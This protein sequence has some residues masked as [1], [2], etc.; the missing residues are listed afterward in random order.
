MAQIKILAVGDVVG[1]GGTDYLSGGRL[2]RTASSLGADVIVVNGENSSK[3]N[4]ITPD[5]AESLF[6]SGADVIT[7]GNHTLKRYHMYDYLDS[8]PRCLRAANYPSDAPGEGYVITDCGGRRLLVISLLGTTFMDPLDSPFKC[9]DRILESAHGKYDL[10]VVDIHAEATSEKM[11][12]AR[13]LDGRVCAVFGTHTHVQ[14]ADACVLP[15]GTGYITDLGM[16]GPSEG[17]LGVKSENAMHKFLRRTPVYFEHAAGKMSAHGA[18]FT[19]DTDTKKCI[20]AAGIS[21]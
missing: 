5:S 18:L 14:T 10:A 15:G 11:C 16:T 12:L 4:C 19:V 7:G 2:R 8:H 13:Y 17:V 1:D 9:A 20:D 6:E 3:A 21:F